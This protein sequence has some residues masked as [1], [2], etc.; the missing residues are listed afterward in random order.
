MLVRDEA[1][2]ISYTLDHLHTQVDEVAIYDNNSTDGTREILQD[3]GELWFEDPEVG[4]Y[5]D[6]KT[7]MAARHANARGHG[8]ILP[9]D[10]DEIWYAPDGRTISEYING[11]APDVRVVTGQLFNHIPSGLDDDKDPNPITRIGWRQRSH[12]ALAKV[13][14]HMGP[15]VMIKMGNHAASFDGHGLVVS[16]LVLRHFSWRSPE[17]YLKK[18]RNG[19]EAYAA[20]DMHDPATFGAHW[21]MFD[22]A[23]DD[24]I[25]DHFR[26]WFYI[27]D[28][29]ADPSLIFD[30]A[31]SGRQPT[32]EES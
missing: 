3:R 11:I 8:W 10:A 15:D 31:P 1:D 25:M 23:T 21:R 2:L 19:S 32:L 4:Y 27:E 17:Q 9:C 13:C 16:G 24:A 18:I 7:T 29:T 14:V 12:G 5:Q 22:G 28:P 20:T 26:K 6:R 30:P